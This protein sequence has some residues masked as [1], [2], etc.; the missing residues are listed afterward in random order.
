MARKIFTVTDEVARRWCERYRLGDSFTK[1]AVDEGY[2]R[3]LV[4]RVVRQFNRLAYLD[5]GIALQREIRSELFREHLEKLE[6]AAWE[7][8]RFTAVLSMEENCV[9]PRNM[10]SSLASLNVE[11]ATADGMKAQLATVTMKRPASTDSIEPMLRSRIFQREAKTIVEDLKTHLPDMWGKVNIWEERSGKYLERWR[12][13]NKRAESARIPLHLF[14]QG[15]QEGLHFLSKSQ[16]EEEFPPY[17][18]N[19]QTPQE[20]G[21]WFFR[22]PKTR[23]LLEECRNSH[24]AFKAVFAQ[25]ESMLIPSEIRYALL[26]RKCAHCPMP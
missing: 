17:R 8:L 22:N 1:I 2:E 7:L 5:E 13:L 16:N 6:K 4:A 19:P 18:D 26:E 9:P 24:T 14:E 23:P 20:V 25:L 3:R 12:E 10:D 11:S 15:V 21:L